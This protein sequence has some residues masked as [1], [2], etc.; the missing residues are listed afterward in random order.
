MEKSKK[1]RENI[2]RNKLSNIAQDNN[3]FITEQEIRNCLTKLVGYGFIVSGKG[4]KGSYITELGVKC[5]EN[6]RGLLGE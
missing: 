1:K 3:L 2:G 4:R 5:N 6:I